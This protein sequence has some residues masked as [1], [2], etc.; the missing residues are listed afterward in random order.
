MDRRQP[1]RCLKHRS[2]A[3]IEERAIFVRQKVEIRLYADIDVELN[4][5]AVRHQHERGRSLFT[6]DIRPSVC[7]SR[8]DSEIAA[9]NH[10][11]ND[12]S[13]ALLPDER[14]RRLWIDMNAAIP[15]RR[16]L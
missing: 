2:A 7:A 5:L 8:I 13:P 4:R 16:I 9:R 10:V 12:L 14:R 11:A 15:G 1:Q 3:Q 6:G